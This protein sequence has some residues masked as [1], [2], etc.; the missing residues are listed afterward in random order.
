[1]GLH[2]ASRATRP[3]AV[4]KI[5][6]WPTS[7]R[8]AYCVPPPAHVQPSFRDRAQYVPVSV[9]MCALAV[10]AR[11]DSSLTTV[12]LGGS[13]GRL[14]Q[15][16]RRTNLTLE[17]TRRVDAYRQCPHHE[18]DPPACDCAGT[19]LEGQTELAT[20]F[21]HLDHHLAWDALPPLR[22]PLPLIRSPSS[23]LCTSVRV[24]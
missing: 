10:T 4:P 8:I 23:T 12:A 16:G 6:L 24:S 11:Q 20:P 9:P 2:G 21:N 19:R 5:P 14:Q 3:C 17:D 13:A 18:T 1:M 7:V 15:N 22:C